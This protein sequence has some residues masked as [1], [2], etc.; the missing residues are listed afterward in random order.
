MVSPRDADLESVQ[1]WRAT[2]HILNKKLQR[3][4]KGGS[5]DLGVQEVTLTN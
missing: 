3:P 2:V 4:E 5:A 1:T